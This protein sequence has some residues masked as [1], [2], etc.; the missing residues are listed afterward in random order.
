MGQNQSHNEP[1]PDS[2][3]DKTL[4]TRHRDE[5][6]ARR[7]DDIFQ[8]DD[9]SEND[10]IS[11]SQE[12]TQPHQ[13][14]TETQYHTP[15]DN[16]PTQRIYHSPGADDDNEKDEK[17]ERDGRDE[18]DETLTSYSLSPATSFYDVA[19]QR[20][21]QQ[22]LLKSNSPFLQKKREHNRRAALEKLRVSSQKNSHLSPSPSLHSSPLKRSNEKSKK[23]IS[24]DEN[25]SPP[26]R[27]RVVAFDPSSSATPPSPTKYRLSNQSPNLAAESKEQ[28]EVENEKKYLRPSNVSYSFE[29]HELSA[30]FPLHPARA[31]RSSFIISNNNVAFSPSRFLLMIQGRL[32]TVFFNYDRLEPLGHLLVAVHSFLHYSECLIAQIPELLRLHL[33]RSAEID[34]GRLEFDHKS[35][36]SINPGQDAVSN[37]LSQDAEIH[38]RSV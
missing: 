26:K 27:P 15:Y 7:R 32:M 5:R 4:A 2:P 20:K 21:A 16:L 12:L 28:K 31:I 25:P 22:T 13:P 18:R 9:D 24:D 10:D 23:E 14:H 11:P 34:V 36:K 19:S 1:E 33:P 3:E 30:E 6:D 37:G 38:L 8:F 29:S 35:G 17:E